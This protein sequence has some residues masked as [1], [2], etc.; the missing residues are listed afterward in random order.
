VESLN[1]LIGMSAVGGFLLG[2]ASTF[3]CSAMCGPLSFFMGRRYAL[4]W[5]FFGKAFAYGLIGLFFGYAGKTI[6]GQTAW[7]GFS[8]YMS[9][10]TAAFLVISAGAVFGWWRPLEL[11][12]GGLEKKMVSWIS[13]LQAT[14][15]AG[16][17]FLAGVLWGFLPCPMVLVP[18]LSAAIAGGVSGGHGALKGFFWMFWFGLGTIP[19]LVLTGSAGA[20]SGSS[21]FKKNAY[22]GGTAYLVLAAFFIYFASAGLPSCHLQQSGS[23]C[24]ASVTTVTE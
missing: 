9:Y 24:C 15:D 7:G 12:L 2:L 11:R 20:L 13:R 21:L 14:R 19:A 1:Q 17:S 4:W 10:F 18:A 16:A 8:K 5:T 23:S 6:A 22:L 3:H